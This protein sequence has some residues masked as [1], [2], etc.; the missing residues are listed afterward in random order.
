MGIELLRFRSKNEVKVESDGL[1]ETPEPGR[2]KVGR[3]RKSTKSDL[4]CSTD[5]EKPAEKQ[6]D[7][8]TPPRRGRPKKVVG[9]S[10]ATAE[11]IVKA[12]VMLPLKTEP[13]VNQEECQSQSS[14]KT[15]P[16]ARVADE[17]KSE[18]IEESVN[19]KIEAD[20]EEKHNSSWDGDAFPVVDCVT[21]VDPLTESDIKKW[22]GSED[23]YEI[24]FSSESLK[25]KINVTEGAVVPTGR[26]RTGLR[27]K[28]PK[29]KS[30][31]IRENREK[32]IKTVPTTSNGDSSTEMVRRL[33]VRRSF[34]DILLAR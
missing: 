18:I 19:L 29:P 10:P 12:E 25:V 28:G 24:P 31:K 26:S 32:V 14:S 23:H 21:A 20:E 33:N 15:A 5:D 3:P 4:E 6:N 7:L 2:R 22:T 17:M 27:I 9:E 30:V 8:I 16:I 13:S 11:I 34:L 1:A